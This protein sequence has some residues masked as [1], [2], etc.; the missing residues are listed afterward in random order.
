MGLFLYGC[1]SPSSSTDPSHA[2]GVVPKALDKKQ[3]ENESFPRKWGCSL[4]TSLYN[5]MIKI[6]PTQVGLFL[7]STNKDADA[8]YP[9]HASGVVPKVSLLDKNFIVSFPRKWGCSQ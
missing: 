8:K 2:S 5:S 3:S 1:P 6:L 4:N 9:S 7:A